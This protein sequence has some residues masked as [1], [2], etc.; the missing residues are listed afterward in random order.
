MNYRKATVGIAILTGA[1][2]IVVWTM[3]KQQ[4][5][6]K[7]VSVQSDYRMQD[8]LLQAFSENGKLAFSLRSPLLERNVDGKSVDIQKPV[9][10]FPDKDNQNW[11]AVSDTAWVSDRAREVQLRN[12]VLITGPISPLGLKTEI[13]IDRISIF[14]KEKRMAS[15]QRVTILHGTSILEGTGLDAKM[16]ERRIRLLAKV[17]ARYVPT[18]P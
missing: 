7:S 1:M 12:N 13:R 16:D 4:D 9:F 6:V 8:F 15:D 5:R 3:Q 10:E 17:K 14:P 2:A 11:T 18:P